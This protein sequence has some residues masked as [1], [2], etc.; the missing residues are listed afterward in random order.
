MFYMDLL[1]FCSV[2]FVFQG[3][4]INVFLWEIFKMYTVDL[5]LELYYIS[6]NHKRQPIP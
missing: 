5:L 2:S 3:P 4:W 1:S 6:E